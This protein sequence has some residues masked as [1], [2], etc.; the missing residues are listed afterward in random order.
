MTPQGGGACYPVAFSGTYIFHFSPAETS[1]DQST[2]YNIYPS[3]YIIQTPGTNIIYIFSKIHTRCWSA[4]GS[5]SFQEICNHS[6]GLITGVLNIRFLN[7][8]T[9]FRHCMY[10]QGRSFSAFLLHLQQI[11]PE[12]YNIAPM[13]YLNH[14]FLHFSLVQSWDVILNLIVV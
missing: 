13:T 4:C 7:T 3:K 6:H 5:R 1:P 14:F 10:V 9:S 8:E 11:I 12:L 2:F